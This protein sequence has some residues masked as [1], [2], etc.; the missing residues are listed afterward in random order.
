MRLLN[1]QTG[2][3][4][5]FYAGAIPPYAILS[6]R[7]GEVEEEVSYKQ[8]RKGH[9]PPDLPGMIKI[10]KFCDLAA[11]RFQWAWIDT[12]CID[13]R[14]SAELSEAINSMYK[15]YERSEECYVHLADVEFSAQEL[16]LK[17]QPGKAFWHT[18]VG[19]Q[20]FKK[21]FS[22]SSWF[23]R[24]WTLQELIAPKKVVFY[25]SRWNE[26]GP[27]EQV[28]KEVA[29]VTGIDH[30]WLGAQNETPYS[31]SIAARMSWASRR[32]TSREEDLAYSLLGLFDVNMPLLYGE[33]AK[34]AFYRLQS[35]IMKL[36][37]DES[38]FAWTSDRDWSGLLADHPKDFA[39]SGDIFSGVFGEII[40]LDNKGAVRPAFSM[41]NLGLKIAVPEEHLQ[42]RFLNDNS[43]FPFFLRC[44][45]GSTKISMPRK[46]LF[47]DLCSFGQGCAIRIDCRTIHEAGDTLISR[48]Y[49]MENLESDLKNSER[50]YIRS[51]DLQ[52]SWD[53]KVSKAF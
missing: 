8:F 47:L 14:S 2:E 39:N 26:I 19:W 46:P 33:G 22:Q 10:Q 15:W 25:D 18:R 13:K 49:L 31:A 28:Y 40:T 34:R 53:F 48:G 44:S 30:R 29:K 3:L 20:S 5:E 37:N 17:N 9:V 7:W 6:H 11:A 23:E 12:C 32:K 4:K 41:T 16:S 45:R 21:K 43:L 50:I 42:A 52:P 38:L 36:S 51:Q 24:G 27:L 35:E 1:T